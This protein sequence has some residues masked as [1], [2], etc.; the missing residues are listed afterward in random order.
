MPGRAVRVGA[1]ARRKVGENAVC[2]AAD[3][4]EG[5]ARVGGGAQ[6]T[7]ESRGGRCAWGR[8]RLGPAHRG[9]S[10]GGGRRAA[11]ELAHTRRVVVPAPP[12]IVGWGVTL[13]NHILDKLGNSFRDLNKSVFK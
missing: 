6:D 4:G 9:L 7:Q 1:A 8:R 10:G 13:Q 11:T 5:A 3:A 12:G 2:G